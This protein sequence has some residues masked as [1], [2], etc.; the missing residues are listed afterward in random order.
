MNFVHNMATLIT[1]AQGKKL[2]RNNKDYVCPVCWAAAETA[3]Q[4]PPY[5]PLSVVFSWNEHLDG[6]T[7]GQRVS[8]AY[9]EV[10]HWRSNLFLVP[11]GKIGKEFVQELARLISAY[12]EG[13]AL[14]SIAIKAA[15]IL[16]TLL[17]Q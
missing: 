2:E 9:D 11:Q 7:F 14:E 16:C 3:V 12:G 10:V 15:M 6:V 8:N 5:T 1:K 4:L 17:L 13:S